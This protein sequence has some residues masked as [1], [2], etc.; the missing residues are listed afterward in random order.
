VKIG[1]QDLVRWL[2]RGAVLLAIVV[3]SN[4]IFHKLSNSF[5]DTKKLKIVIIGDSNTHSERN[6]TLDGLGY[7]YARFIHEK[8]KKME[9]SGGQSFEI[10]NQG[11]RGDGIMDLAGRWEKDVIQEKPTILSVSIG[12]ND[13]T[14]KRLTNAEFERIYKA[15]LTQTKIALPNVKIL[16]LE[17]YLVGDGPQ[18]IAKKELLQLKKD[19]T[20]KNVIIRGIGKDMRI[21]VVKLEELM[22]ENPDHD[23][24]F[25]PEKDDGI[26][27]S[28]HG[29]ER[30]TEAWIR[31]FH[32]E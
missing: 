6:Y 13:A 20:T 9:R 29:H 8:F 25:S 14:G 15:L 2:V 19:L 5:V 12:I 24:D 30:I 18:N 23:S 27:I 1:I 17:V 32:E 26:H 31:A 21:A 11:A 4:Q 10:L 28:Q 3:C 7:G 22:R 16:L